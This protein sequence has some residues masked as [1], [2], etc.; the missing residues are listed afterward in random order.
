[1]SST[2][3]TVL[4]FKC[5]C[6]FIKDL[7]DCFGNEQKSLLL[8]AHLV[9]N[10]GIIHE[11]PIRKHIRCFHDF[12][13]ANEE[14]I[15]T[16]NFD[17][18]EEPI[19]R[20]S[21]KVFI[22]MAD[23][24]KRA[25]ASE[26]EVIWKHLVTILAVLDPSSQAKKMLLEEQEKKKS[27][28]ETGNEEEFLTNII[29]KVGSQIDPSTANPAEMMTNLMSSGIFTEL[30]DN[31]NQGLTKGDLDLGKM[32]GSLQSMMGNL[33]TMVASASAQQPPSSS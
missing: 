18:C 17:L 5:I 14:A 19:I 2:D 7:N 27:K 21:D 22:D 33:N 9:E 12:V 20:Y 3:S 31:M 23:V 13:K 8:Y 28:G 32:I 4:I 26:K 24:F 1:M 10:T 11:E 25:D 15:M 29:N 30:V 16:K 6:S